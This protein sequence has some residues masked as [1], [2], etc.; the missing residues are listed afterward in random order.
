MRCIE[1]LDTDRG[2]VD[3]GIKTVSVTKRPA[4]LLD[5]SSNIK[6]LRG[7]TCVITAVYI[8]SILPAR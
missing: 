6:I 4:A 5:Y 2:D 3:I 7:N 1:N 8:L